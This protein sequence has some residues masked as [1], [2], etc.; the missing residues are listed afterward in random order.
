MITLKEA[1]VHGVVVVKLDEPEAF[2][3]ASVL[4]RQPCDLFDLAKLRKV[5]ENLVVGDLFFETAQKQLL[6]GL[7]GLRLAKLFT[8]SCTLRLDRF[9]IDGVR[10]GFLAGVD[11]VLGGISHESEAARPFGVWKLHHY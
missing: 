1:L 11:L 2:L 7:A 9:A 6:D 4:V 10:P 5:L 3:L 8:G